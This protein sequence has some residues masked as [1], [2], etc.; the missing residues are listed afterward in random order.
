M[1]LPNVFE[2][3]GGGWQDKGTHQENRSLPFPTRRHTVHIP[4]IASPDLR[5]A[6]LDARVALGVDGADGH[7]DAMPLNLNCPESAIANTSYAP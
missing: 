6:V 4:I 3:D 7:D 5:I 1:F 2:R